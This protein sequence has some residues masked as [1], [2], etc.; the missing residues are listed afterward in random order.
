MHV[1]LTTST[2][3]VP[4]CYC[5]HCTYLEAK[6]ARHVTREIVFR[7]DKHCGLVSAK[8]RPLPQARHRL[9]GQ[10]AEG[11]G[12]GLLLCAVFVRG[13][14]EGALVLID[15]IYRGKKGGVK[16]LRASTVKRGNM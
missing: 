15:E 3:C 14:E 11:G 2:K 9:C 13:A 1:R 6:V 12:G 16:T 4:L 10:Q 7:S 8:C 5:T